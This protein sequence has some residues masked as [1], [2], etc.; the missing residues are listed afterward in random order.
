[1]HLLLAGVL[2]TVKN[3]G[4]AH[5]ILRRLTAAQPWPP[6]LPHPP[7]T[8]A[9]AHAI[10]PCCT[11]TASS[12]NAF[13]SADKAI[14]YHNTSM[15]SVITPKTTTLIRWPPIIFSHSSQENI[16]LIAHQHAKKPIRQNFFSQ[17]N[18]SDLD[19]M[20]CWPHRA[21]TCQAGVSHRSAF[22]AH[23][24]AKRAC[25]ASARASCRLPLIFFRMCASVMPTACAT[26][27]CCSERPLK[28]QPQALQSHT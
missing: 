28:M 3:R 9:A 14:Y 24:A 26:R 1:M 16:F 7:A 2:S 15:T 23:A 8:S 20:F 6:T 18:R 10:S 4:R 5:T 13:R 22:T 19:R 21:S 27:L 12:A 11:S 17:D 25:A